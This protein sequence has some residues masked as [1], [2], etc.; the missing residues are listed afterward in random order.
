M[1]G[2]F[3]LGMAVPPIHHALRIANVILAHDRITDWLAL[4]SE[5]RFC[6]GTEDLSRVQ[7]RSASRPQ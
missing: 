1:A 7:R 6:I 4:D 3:A 5:A 2:R